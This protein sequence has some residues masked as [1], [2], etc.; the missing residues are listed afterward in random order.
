MMP[1]NERTL[2][3]LIGHAANQITLHSKLVIFST[4]RTPSDSIEQRISGAQSQMLARLTI[5][6]LDE[7]WKLIS[8][9]FLASPIGKEFQPKLNAVGQLALSELKK[10]FGGSNLISGLR[11]NFAFH[12]PYDSDVEAGFEA[13]ASDKNWDGDWNWYFSHGTFNSFYFLSDVVILHSILAAVGETD[14]VEAQRKIMAEVRNVSEHMVNFLQALNE[15]LLVKHFAPEMQAKVV[16]Q[17]G[18]APSVFAPWIPFYV[19]IPAD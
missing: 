6:V 18:D 19:E 17:I 8:K 7:T 12:H 10:H 3:F 9:R 16:A 15:A 14:L 13:A 1:K 2:L 4:N 5:G 11:N